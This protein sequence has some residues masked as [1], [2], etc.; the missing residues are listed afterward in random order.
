MLS[1]DGISGLVCLAIGIGLL[2]QT[3]G[4]PPAVMVPIGPAFYPRVV[5]GLM[6]FLSVLLIVLDF[7]AMRQ[8]RA[9]GA[10]AAAA[11]PGAAPNYRLVLLTFIEFGL[12]IALLPGLGFRIATFLFVLAL[13]VTLEWPRSAKHWALAVI[14]AAATAAI[15]HFVFEG[16]LSV[17]LPRGTWSGM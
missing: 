5:L 7:R 6:L 4:L 2:L 8:L 11:A 1:R 15:C 16:Y 13:Q 17:L 9:A 14:V 12:Y 10:P 3:I